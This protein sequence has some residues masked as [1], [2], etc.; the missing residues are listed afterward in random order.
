MR[1]GLVIACGC[2]AALLSCSG[3]HKAE[4]RGGLQTTERVVRSFRGTVTAIVQITDF[5][6]EALVVDGDPCWVVTVVLSADDKQKKGEADERCYAIHSP[7][8]LFAMSA[9]EA[10]NKTFDFTEYETRDEQGKVSW[11]RL[12]AVSL[13][14]AFRDKID[15]IVSPSAR[16]WTIMPGPPDG[17][18]T[19]VVNPRGERFNI[20]ETAYPDFVPTTL[21]IVQVKEL[22]AR[23]LIIRVPPRGLRSGWDGS[24]L[25]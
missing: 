6:G 8:K 12:E 10:L 23:F 16:G 25:P 24:G 20:G 14:V 22:N 13:E 3:E 2:V 5:S 7:T 11:R 4:P 18:T 19:V 21:W 1:A 9:E 17:R 15:P